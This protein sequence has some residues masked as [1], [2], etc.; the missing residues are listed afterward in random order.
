MIFRSKQEILEALYSEEGLELLKKESCAKKILVGDDFVSFVFD[1]GVMFFNLSNESH[2]KMCVF[3]NSK[4]NTEESFNLL[5]DVS[6]LQ[7]SVYLSCPKIVSLEVCS[8]EDSEIKV[9]NEDIVCIEDKAIR[10]N[11]KSCSMVGY[12]GKFFKEQNNIETKSVKVYQSS[13]QGSLLFSTNFFIGKTT[14]QE[15]F[16][17]YKDEKFY[18][19]MCL[20]NGKSYCPVS[21]EDLFLTAGDVA[22]LKK[23]IERIM[24]NA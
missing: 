9:I 13:K 5:V 8:L 2:N 19:M 18:H 15:D 12:R 20:Q 23:D 7:D 1:E 6:L 3:K 22:K 14:S 16:M 11:S 21:S 10:Y 24:N 4:I 17:L